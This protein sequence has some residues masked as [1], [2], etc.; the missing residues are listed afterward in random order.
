MCIASILITIF[1]QLAVPLPHFLVPR[2]REIPASPYLRKHT[3]THV[4][5]QTMPLSVAELSRLRKRPSKLLAISGF[6]ESRDG[7]QR[8]FRGNALI[9]EACTE[10]W[11]GVRCIWSLKQTSFPGLRL[12][13]ADFCRRS[14][15][16]CRCRLLAPYTNMYAPLYWMTFFRPRFFSQAGMQ[17]KPDVHPASTGSE[18]LTGQLQGQM[19]QIKC[20]WSL[21]RKEELVMP[22]QASLPV[23]HVQ[24]VFIQRWNHASLFQVCLTN[25]LFMSEALLLLKRSRCRWGTTSGPEYLRPC[26]L[27]ASHTVWA[28]IN[29]FI[30]S[31]CFLRTAQGSCASCRALWPLTCTRFTTAISELKRIQK[32]SVVRSSNWHFLLVLRILNKKYCTYF[33]VAIQYIYID[34]DSDPDATSN[35]SLVHFLWLS[36]FNL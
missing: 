9:C 15:G 19:S 8:G 22:V 32:A 18:L 27:V 31:P 13:A 20:T 7:C 34:P 24:N 30:T 12:H 1:S 16:W 26:S 36:G 25:L 21:L 33:N 2:W 11:A 4:Q 17:G 29:L 6:N 35:S 14:D 28:A 5:P 10:L 23:V 3:Y